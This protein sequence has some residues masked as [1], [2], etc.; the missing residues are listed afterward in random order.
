MGMAR[1]NAWVTAV[2]DP[3]RIDEAYQWYVHV[4]HCDGS[5]LRWCGRRF[6]NIP[7]KCG[8][9][10]IEIP[11]GTYMVCATWSP[12]P[13]DAPEVPTTLGNHI[14]HLAPVRVECGEEACVTLFPPTL[15]FCG[16]WIIRA[17]RANMQFRAVDR[18]LGAETIGTIERLLEATP[19]DPF[20]EN[21]M[22]ID[23]EEPPAG[24]PKATRR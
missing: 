23:E 13:H 3:C 18:K 22:A 12:A 19:P 8:H 2:G 14:T 4:L 9:A 17:I 6:F 16:W 21:M 15:H 7:T 11:P 24:G 1:L 10:E 5:I 20:T